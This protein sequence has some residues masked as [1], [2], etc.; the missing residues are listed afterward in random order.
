[1]IDSGSNLAEV[2]ASQIVDELDRRGRVPSIFGYGKEEVM[3]AMRSISARAA[4]D[5]LMPF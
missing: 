2:V 3:N 5:F 1:M 4:L